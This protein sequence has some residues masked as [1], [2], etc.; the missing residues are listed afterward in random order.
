MHPCISSY[1]RHGDITCKN[2][3]IP[4]K[5]HKKAIDFIFQTFKKKTKTRRRAMLNEEA[6][7][8]ISTQHIYT[9]FH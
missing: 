3:H 7:T 2:A 9:I 4:N 6:L 5:N 1:K 8:N